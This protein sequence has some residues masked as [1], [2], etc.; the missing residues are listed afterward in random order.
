V[1]EQ[2]K[3]FPDTV[4]FSRTYPI[5]PLIT[6]REFK[7]LGKRIIYEIDDDLWTVNPDNPSVAMSEEKRRQY[8]HLMDECDAITT[9]TPIL[10]K[11]LRKFNKNVF[12]CPNAINFEMF[13]TTKEKMP[14]KSLRIGYSG[15]SSHWAD[16]NILPEVL[17]KLQK[18]YDFEFILQGMCA[19]PLEAEIWGYERVLEYN[20]QP[21]KKLY[22]ENAVKWYKNMRNVK[23]FHVPFYP[24]VMFPQIMTTLDLD[25]GIIPLHDNEFNHSKCLTAE[26][27][28]M[29]NGGIKRI[30]DVLIGDK[31]FQ[32]DFEE[33]S[34][35]IKYDKKNII[36]I[37]TEDGY[38]LKGTTNHKIMSNGCW[39][40]L[41][42]LKMGDTIELSELR[43]PKLKYR[44]V[45]MPFLL[46]KNIDKNWKEGNMMP[47]IEIDENWG[48]LLGYFLGDGSF[49]NNSIRISCST[50]YP[51]IIQ[52]VENLAKEMG[53]KTATTNK[54]IQDKR[55]PE[56]NKDGKGRDITISS[57]NLTILLESLGLRDKNGRRIIKTPDIIFQSPKLVVKEYIKG[58]FETDG[59]IG[60]RNG[61]SFTNKDERFVRD[62]QFLLMCFG[63]K[64]KVYGRYNKVYQRWYWNLT[65]KSLMCRKFWQEIGFISEKKNKRLFELTQR[66][67]SNNHDKCEMFE[68]IKKI[69]C[70]QEDVYDIEIPNKNYYIANGFVSHNS[71]I[72]FY[73]SATI[74]AA[75]L[76]SNVLPYKEEVGYCAKN[77]VKD[78]YNK[79]E[80]LIVNVKFR[81]ELAEKQ[82]KWVKENRDIEKVA[83]NWE[84]AFDPIQK[85]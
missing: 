57:R 4:V 79:L 14:K 81:K 1:P 19:Q 40:E 47:R 26:T 43:F 13:K 15:A 38:K 16:L 51:D 84:D 78:W 62:L 67:I 44:E 39:K 3:T 34:A 66:K 17:E 74:G 7:R 54:K 20:L 45:I 82:L 76:A 72:K 30:K 56:M 23:M 35:N 32:N 60:K 83:I 31:V 80:K 18:K 36:E 41:D 71:C 53:L 22:L 49:A 27:L 2:S 33:V 12:V 29:T 70:G 69:T 50:D 48:R 68:K 28:V 61:C 24:P 64:S 10:A 58:L 25:I 55:F 46:S 59:T 37:E 63:I 6:L 11:K 9:T 77:N 8:E 85:K 21:E 52:D 73:E 42:K 65:I 75:T 5:D